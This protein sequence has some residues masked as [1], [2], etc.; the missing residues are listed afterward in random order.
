MITREYLKAGNAVF[1]VSN[2]AGETY[3]I[4]VQHGRPRSGMPHPFWV[5]VSTADGALRDYEY[6]GMLTDNGRVVATRTS[7]HV[8]GSRTFSIVAWAMKCVWVGKL[9]EGY[10][11]EW[12]GRCGKCGRRVTE[13]I[14]GFGP[15]CYRSMN[16]VS[17]NPNCVSGDRRLVAV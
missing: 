9:P 5:T 3:F 8:K 2:P 12:A 16:N 15:E 1:K 13:N 6:V 17:D 4:R 7:R 14:N 10:K 11:I